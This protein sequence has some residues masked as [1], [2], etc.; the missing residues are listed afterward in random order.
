MDYLLAQDS[1]NPC[2]Y[3][4]FYP[5][6]ISDTPIIPL[7]VKVF[8]TRKNK[9]IIFCCFRCELLKMFNNIYLTI[10]EQQ[11]IITNNRVHNFSSLQSYCQTIELSTYKGSAKSSQPSTEIVLLSIK[12][13]VG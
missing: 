3:F 5:S 4:H 13:C 10:A 2:F 6:K 11:L 7:Y 8:S 9:A 1:Q 12:F